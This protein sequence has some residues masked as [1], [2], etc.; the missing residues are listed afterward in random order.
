MPNRKLAHE[1]HKFYR[2]TFKNSGTTIYRCGIAGC[3]TFLYEPLVIGRLSICWRCGDT[4][5]VI[6]RTIRNKKFHCEDCT[7]GYRGK[8]KDLKLVKEANELI[9]SLPIQNQ[10][11][12]NVEK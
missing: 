5:V 11:P 9:E 6:K 8:E 12:E 7:R 4:F 2:T 1:I 3:S 10:P